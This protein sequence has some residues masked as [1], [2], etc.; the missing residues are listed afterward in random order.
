MIFELI[1]QIDRMPRRRHLSSVPDSPP[2]ADSIE[3]ADWRRAVC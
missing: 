1:R 2:H 3:S